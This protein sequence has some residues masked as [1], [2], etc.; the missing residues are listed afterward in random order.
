MNRADTSLAAGVTA[1][2]LRDT[3]SAEDSSEWSPH[4]SGGTWRRRQTDSILRRH[5]AEPVNLEPPPASSVPARLF[6]ALLLK[7]RFGSA[8]QWRRRSLG[9]A[10]YSYRFYGHNARR[11]GLCRVAL[12]ESGSDP[13]AG[14][15]LKDEGFRVVAVL[16]AINSLWRSRPNDVTGPYPRMFLTE[17]R[18]LAKLDAVFCISREEQWL[19]NNVGIP[20]N[21]LPYFPDEARAKAFMAER[22]TRQRPS[23]FGP[24]EFMICASR[25]NSDTVNAFRDQARWI[26]Q[27]VSEGDAIFHVTGHQTEPIKDIWLDKRFVFH[28]TC[29]DEEFQ[30]VKQGCVAICLHQ[31]EGIGALTRIPDM[32]LSGLAVIAN[33][34]AARSFIDLPGV[35]VYDTPGKFRELLQAALPMPPLPQRPVELEDA[36]F[37][38]LR[39]Q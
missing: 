16:S 5:G 39:L 13:I 36:F 6:R 18:A 11:P 30:A 1:R 3:F 28:G 23:A 32:I 14:A 33:G 24:R 8:I 2:V 29:S 21:Y 35:H 27:A 20:A 17:T 26:C 25:G 4:G 34:P 19:L 9:Q 31:R 38:A 12:L 37:A 15:A 22:E 10:E 7:R